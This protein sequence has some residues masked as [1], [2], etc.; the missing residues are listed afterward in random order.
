M[1]HQSSI[2]IGGKT[3]LLDVISCTDKI[4]YKIDMIA[5]GGSR[6]FQPKNI[7]LK[8]RLTLV[9]TSWG[10]ITPKKSCPENGIAPT[11][12]THF[13]FLDAVNET[14]NLHT[15]VHPKYGE[16]H[17]VIGSIEITHDDRDNYVEIIFEFLGEIKDE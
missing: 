13:D 14:G 3:F 8:T 12:D 16:R 4:G 9:R 10:A 5:S 17:G 7:G 15:F 1:D 11:Y 6:I 2:A